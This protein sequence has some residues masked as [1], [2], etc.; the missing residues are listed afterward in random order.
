MSDWRTWPQRASRQDQEGEQEV[1]GRSADGAEISEVAA[2]VWT[3]LDGRFT[4]KDKKNWM[5]F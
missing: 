3:E 2:A 4:I 5:L 1:T